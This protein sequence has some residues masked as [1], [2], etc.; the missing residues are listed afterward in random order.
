MVAGLSAHSVSIACSNRGANTFNAGTTFLSRIP[1]SPLASAVR[2]AASICS[3]PRLFVSLV[4]SRVAS[5]FQVNLFPQFLLFGC[6]LDRHHLP[7]FFVAVVAFFFPLPLG[8]PPFFPISLSSSFVYLFVRALPPIAPV[9]R[10]YSI[11]SS[12]M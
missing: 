11:T 5:P 3:E 4:L 2:W 10:K 7:P 1:T 12:G 6:L 8:R 9:L